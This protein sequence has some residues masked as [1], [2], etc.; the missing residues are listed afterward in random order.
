MIIE[1]NKLQHAIQCIF[2]H[3][4]ERGVDS[5]EISEDFYWNFNCDEV[6]DPMKSPSDLDLG[7]LSDDWNR[8]LSIVNGDNPALGYSLVW[9][10]PILRRIGE[11]NVR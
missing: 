6:Y 7:Q 8:L 4:S 1:L 9:A 5:V 11:L 3:L 2:E 10:A